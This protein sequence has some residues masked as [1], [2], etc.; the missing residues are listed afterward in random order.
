M[1]VFI[2]IKFESTNQHC[3]RPTSATSVIAYMRR[4]WIQSIRV[5]ETILQS[6]YGSCSV[7]A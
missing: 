5:L 2:Y 7:D 1:N 6:Y 3:F 4:R